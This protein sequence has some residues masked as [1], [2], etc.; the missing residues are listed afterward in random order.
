MTLTNV[1]LL[2][3]THIIYVQF[4]G[5]G[6]ETNDPMVETVPAKI[7]ATH[8]IV[9]AQ[10]TPVHVAPIVHTAPVVQ[11]VPKIS[12]NTVVAPSVVASVP[13]KKKRVK[14]AKTKR[15]GPKRPP[16]SFILYSM[17]MRP[18]IRAERPDLKTVGARSTLLASMWKE[19]AQDKKQKYLDLAK[20]RKEKYLEEMEVFKKKLAEQSEKAKQEQQVQE[21][22]KE[23]ERLQQQ[24]QNQQYLQQ[25]Q[26]QQQQQ[27][28]A[29]A[30]SVGNGTNE[31]IAVPVPTEHV[32]PIPVQDVVPVPTVYHGSAAVHSVPTVANI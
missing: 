22:A 27:V 31:E 15:M 3:L 7:P 21:Q 11:T 19:L 17:E 32:S 1:L 20:Q 25:Q 13:I 23:Q 6:Y 10:T 24:I 2:L 16:S 4:M 28:H 14:K 12:N 26:Q 29:Q 18:K 8:T 30:I 5:H 9:G